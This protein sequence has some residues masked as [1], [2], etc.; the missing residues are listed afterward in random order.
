[1]TTANVWRVMR[2][3]RGRWKIENE[4]FNTLKTQGYH[5]EHNY[6]HGEE[7]LSDVFA[8]LMMLAFFVDQVLQL[9]DPLFQGA[10]QKL[11]SKRLLWNACGHCFT[12]TICDL[13][14]SCMKRCTTVVNGH[15]PNKI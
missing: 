2:A 3:G 9:C 4:T 13:C 6:G 10:L 7:N 1:V 14:A 5:Y 11:G 15:A 8:L 12:N